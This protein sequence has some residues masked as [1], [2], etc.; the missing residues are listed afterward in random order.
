MSLPETLGLN[1][2]C[3]KNPRCLQS[4]VLEAAWCTAR[5]LRTSCGRCCSS[6]KLSITLS[7]LPITVSS[8]SPQAPRHP[9]LPATLSPQYAVECSQIHS[10]PTI[11]F[12]INGTALPLRPSAYVLNVCISQQPHPAGSR[13]E[14]TWCCFFLGGMAMLSFPVRAD[15]TPLQGAGAFLGP[16]SPLFPL[17]R[18][19]VTAPLAS[20]PPTWAPS[21]GSRSG[22]WVT[23]SSRSI[24]P[25]STWRKTASASPHRRR[26]GG[27]EIQ[28]AL[29]ECCG[30]PMGLF[31]PFRA[32]CLSKV[33]V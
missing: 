31:D 17:C 29:L 20:R 28:R 2:Y 32:L 16:D 11:T 8:P 33:S 24:T 7:K 13:R 18:A 9:E 25:S 3:K 10:L 6:P 27:S 23:S 30:V 19:M 12:V 15:P 1:R 4:T 26:G 14:R 22:F 5:A 21:T